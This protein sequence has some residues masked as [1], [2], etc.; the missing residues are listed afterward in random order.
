MIRVMVVDD[1][2]VVRA[3][4]SM[5]LGRFDDL[6]LVAA[7]ADGETAIELARDNDIDVILMDLSMPG[8][9]GAEATRRILRESPEVRIVVLTTFA[10]RSHVSEA[11]D[12]G[13]MGYL[14]KDADPTSLSSAIRSAHRGEAPLDPRAASVLI[15]R[16][17]SAGATDAADLTPREREILALVGDGLSNRQIARRLDIAERTVKSHLTKAFAAIGADDRVQ[18]ALWWQ[19]HHGSRQ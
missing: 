18:A 1:H 2:E 17:R 15:D 7:A 9:G 5:L 19:R 11:I 13:A 14:L 8:I 12:A 3:G 16:R 10:D 6:R 4:L